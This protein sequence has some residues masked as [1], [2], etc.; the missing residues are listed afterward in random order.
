MEAS[1]SIYSKALSSARPKPFFKPPKEIFRRITAVG[2]TQKVKAKS[3]KLG[4]IHGC[5]FETKVQEAGSES[6]YT[7]S[8][9]ALGNFEL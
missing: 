8:A 3:K 5:I 7:A 2:V 4:L 1:A 6:E 9:W